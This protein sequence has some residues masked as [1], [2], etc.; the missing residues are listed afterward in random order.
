MDGIVKLV[1]DGAEVLTI[2]HRETDTHSA[3]PSESPLT[4]RRRTDELGEEDHELEED[5]LRKALRVEPATPDHRQHAHDGMRGDY[6]DPPKRSE[7]PGTPSS[8]GPHDEDGSPPVSA[9]GDQ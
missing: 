7:C 4:R 6:V 9:G 5:G 8:F 1:A 2:M 3:D